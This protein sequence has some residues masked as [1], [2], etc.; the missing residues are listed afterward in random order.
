MSVYLAA[1]HYRAAQLQRTCAYWMATEY[2]AATAQAQWG[3]LPEAVREEAR[4]EHARLVAKREAMRA[5]RTL[6]QQVPCV[7]AN[8]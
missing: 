4:A 5:E 7:F 8:V 2:E 6:M 1:A 3:E